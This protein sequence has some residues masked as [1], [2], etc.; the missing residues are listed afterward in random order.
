M[1]F[2][3]PVIGYSIEP[4]KQID[5]DRLST[6]IYK[7]LEE[8]PTLK[9]SVDNETGQTI[10]SGMGEL[11]L[12]II[13]DRLKREFN[14]EVNKGEPRVA[15]KEALTKTVTHQEIYK[16]QTGGRGKF[17][18]ILFEIGPRLDNK[19]GLEFINAVVGGSIPKEF[20]PSVKKGF[21]SSMKNGPLIGSPIES[22]RIKLIKGSFH[23]V[24]SDSLSFEIVA[25][26]G[27][28][29]AIKQTN[30]ILMEP[31]MDVEVSMPSEFIG[32][33]TGD[34][35]KRRGIMKE[36]FIKNNFQIIKSQVPLSSLFGYVTD[37]RTITSGR[38]F[39]SLIF[40]H[41]N[42]VLQSISDDII[43]KEKGF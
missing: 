43:K 17:A 13:L 28:K 18:D 6:S 21:E 3:D 22:M 4:K 29:N 41:Y 19:L 36:M 26:I 11:H 5:V 30:V 31:I 20:I 38:G 12:D 8:D 40:S 16:K 2:P 25:T 42:K 10:L 39:S 34:L 27:F 23:E 32:P 14:V 33:V 7:L 35:N 1:N 9:V 15:Y 37:L 24:D